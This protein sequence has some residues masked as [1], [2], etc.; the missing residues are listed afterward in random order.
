MSD[1]RPIATI[2]EIPDQDADESWLD[3]E[4]QE[5]QELPFNRPPLSRFFMHVHVI[6]RV[7][8]FF[9]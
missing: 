2:E 7:L 5:Y 9:D 1:A 4:T 6:T 3:S 8:G